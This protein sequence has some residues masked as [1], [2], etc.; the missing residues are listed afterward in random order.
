M[1]ADDFIAIQQLLAR[2]NQT[3]DSGDAESW[4]SCFTPDGSFQGRAGKVTGAQALADYAAAAR[5]RGTYRHMTGNIYIE[6]GSSPDRATVHSHMIYYTL[7]QQPVPTIEL[8]ARQVDQVVKTEK[9]WRIAS[10]VLTVD[11]PS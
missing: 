8:S 5:S 11:Q 9:G 4:A 6:S 2:Y 10:R 7:K 3:F 1:Q